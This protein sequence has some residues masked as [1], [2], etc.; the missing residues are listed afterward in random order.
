M[1]PTPEPRYQRRIAEM[2]EQVRQFQ[3]QAA[4]RRVRLRDRRTSAPATANP[5]LRG[6]THRAPAGMLFRP[7][8]SDGVHSS[9]VAFDTA[10]RPPQPK[11]TA[12]TPAHSRRIRSSMKGRGAALL[13][14]P[15]D[16]GSI[17]APCVGKP[18]IRRWRSCQVILSRLRSAVTSAACRELAL[19]D[20]VQLVGHG[21]YCQRTC[22]T[23]RVPGAM[24]I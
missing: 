2:E 6:R 13:P 19:V 10:A 22:E 17:H 8:G 7:S 14:N 24:S 4:Q 11:A 3:Q 18:P 15:F 5:R 20:S 16:D 1:E 9:P 23:H 21:G 12:S